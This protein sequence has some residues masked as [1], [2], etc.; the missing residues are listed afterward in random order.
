MC[1]LRYF[2]TSGVRGEI[3]SSLTPEL[4]VKLSLSFAEFLGGSGRVALGRDARLSSPVLYDAV[5]VAAVMGGLDVCEVGVVPTP[6]LLHVV[7]SFGLD[8]AIMVTASHTPANYSGLL[9]FKGDGAELTAEESAS[10]ERFLEHL[11]SVSWSDFGTVE[12]CGDVVELYVKSV[13]KHLDVRRLRRLDVKV[14]AD[15]CNSPY[16]PYLSEL[17]GELGLDL[18][19]VNDFPSGFFPGRG[20]DL[21]PSSLHYL[22]RLIPDLGFDIGFGLISGM[23]ER[24]ENILFVCYDNEAY[25]NTGMQASGATPWGSSTTTTPSGDGPTIDAIGSHQHKKNM[26]DIALAHGVRYVAQSTAGYIDDIA[27]KVKRAVEIEGPAYIQIL[28]PCIPGWKIKSDEAMKMG[29]LAAQSGLYPLLEYE[30]GELIKAMKTPEKRPSV[31]EY[32]KPQGRFAHLF[33]DKRGKEQLKL[34]QKIADANIARYGI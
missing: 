30:N 25:S 31:E 24:G 20:A 29:R 21:K 8:G 7:K 12:H 23:W 33:K 14:I 10:L 28:S 5:A 34:I 2:G 9:F 3:D 17:A 1:S 19:T 18:L 11:P 13:C 27:R 4:A 22:S 16:A 32:L 26:I 6:V 15:L